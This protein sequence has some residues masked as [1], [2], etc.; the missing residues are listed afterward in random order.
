MRG[1]ASPTSG[2]PRCS[3]VTPTRTTW[4]SVQSPHVYV[5][6]ICQCPARSSPAALGTDEM[7]WASK[8]S[9]HAAIDN[10]APLSWAACATAANCR[11]LPRAAASGS[12]WLRNVSHRASSR[13]ASPPRTSWSAPALPLSFSFPRLEACVAASAVP[14][15]SAYSRATSA[16]ASRCAASFGDGPGSCGCGC[17]AAPGA[18]AWEGASLGE[19][20]SEG[21][22]EAAVGAGPR[23]SNLF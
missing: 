15:R 1:N 9:S 6:Q 8:A 21:T 19:A 3:S 22:F 11:R 10:G 5:V 16:S 12:T 14:C 18:S 4:K 17:R 20:A 13:R 7:K 23:G 2:P